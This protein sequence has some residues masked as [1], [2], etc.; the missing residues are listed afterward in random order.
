MDAPERDRIDVLENPTTVRAERLSYVDFSLD[1]GDSDL[2]WSPGVLP[3]A[4]KR[5]QCKARAS[6]HVGP[7]VVFAN[8]EF[9]IYQR[10]NRLTDSE[11]KGNLRFIGRMDKALDPSLAAY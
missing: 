6:L 2:E 7:A 1:T 3:F 11:G 8:S 4:H 10:G 5:S 9:V